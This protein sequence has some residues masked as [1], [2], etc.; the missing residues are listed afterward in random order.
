M[1]KAYRNLSE[2]S[3]RLKA[4]DL[5]DSESDFTTDDML[6]AINGVFS[7]SE[8]SGF[9]GAWI[10]EAKV[11]FAFDEKEMPSKSLRVLINKRL[12]EIGIRGRVETSE[13][14]LPKGRHDTIKYI[15]VTI[16]RS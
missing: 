11:V 5:C 3:A 10:D 8:D 2:L 14:Y 7:L 9:Y 13:P 16:K 15:N 6:K 4:L 12:N 1:R